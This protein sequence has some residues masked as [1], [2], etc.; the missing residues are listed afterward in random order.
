MS[1]LSSFIP[2]AGI[3]YTML[4]HFFSY[5]DKIK[6]DP[7]YSADWASNPSK[8]KIS[9]FIPELFT[10]INNDDELF[11]DKI[12]AKDVDKNELEHFTSMSEALVFTPIRLSFI[13]G[14]LLMIIIIRRVRGYEQ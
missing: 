6:S 14:I 3:S 1:F 10:N 8:W 7:S 12:I 4:L 11:I 9:D 13:I 2:T 5:D